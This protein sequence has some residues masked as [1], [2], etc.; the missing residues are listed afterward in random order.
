LRDA[1]FLE[2][3]FPRYGNFIL[4]FSTLWK[5]NFH[6]V[7]KMARAGVVRAGIFHGVEKS[8]PR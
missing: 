8:L 2:S 1:G 6:S 4:R 3:V 7:E 5:N